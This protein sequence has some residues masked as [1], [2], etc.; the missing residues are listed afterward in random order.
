MLVTLP[1]PISELQHAPLPPKVLRTKKRA[2]TPGSFVVF[3]LDSHLSPLR[4]LGACHH[5]YVNGNL[6]HGTC[7]SKSTKQMSLYVLCVPKV[8]GF[9]MDPIGVGVHNET[10]L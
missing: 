5:T 3:N 2:I 7:D 10:N 1:S 6:T 8:K 4:N 9:Y